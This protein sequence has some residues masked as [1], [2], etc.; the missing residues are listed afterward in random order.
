LEN[1]IDIKTIL[2]EG[3]RSF[4]DVMERLGM[5][6]NNEILKVVA[7]FL[8]APL[9]D[10]SVNMGYQHWLHKKSADEFWVYFCK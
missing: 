9:I 5:L 2:H 7:S 1:L 8:P 3:D 6:G 4:N 10:K